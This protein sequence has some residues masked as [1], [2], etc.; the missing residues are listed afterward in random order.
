VFACF[1]DF[2]KAFDHVNYWKLFSQLISDNIEPAVVALL[3]HWYSHQSVYVLWHGV[4]SSSFGIGNGTRQGGQLSPILFNRYVTDLI[5]YI[6]DSGIRC[7]VGG[8]M[9]NILAYADDMVL[10]CPSW[11]AMQS[12]IA[13]LDLGAS[14]YDMPCNTAK[15]VRMM[16]SPKDKRKT[17]SRVFPNFV[18]NGADVHFVSDFKY[19]G[20]QLSVNQSDDA[21]VMR[22][23]SAMFTRTNILIRHFSKCSVD[24]KTVLFRSYCLSFYGTALW[25]KCT[26][27]MKNRM[28]SCYNRCI[29]LF[30]GFSKFHSVT[31]MLLELGFLSFDTVLCN[32]KSLFL[33]QL[34][35]CTNG[36]IQYLLQLTL[37]D[38]Q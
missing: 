7:N 13:M 14:N 16:F 25:E 37:Y 35:K 30:F 20:F 36:I 33:S 34:C 23:I 4:V 1:V 15:T 8:M 31:N 17:V 19:L 11:Y 32:S 2:S 3:A 26:V 9:L 12:L 29:K 6:R 10:I 5:V 27:R 38:V 28:K 24:V 18:L 22:E 21:D